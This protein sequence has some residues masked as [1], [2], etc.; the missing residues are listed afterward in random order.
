MLEV[1]WNFELTEWKYNRYYPWSSNDRVNV[2]NTL[3]CT[4]HKDIKVHSP[5]EYILSNKNPSLSSEQ[6]CKHGMA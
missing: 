3:K 5:L 2:V 6:N 1:K 4:K